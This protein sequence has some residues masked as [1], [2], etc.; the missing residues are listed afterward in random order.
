MFSQL[1]HSKKKNNNQSPTNDPSLSAANT[2]LLTLSQHLVL[3]PLFIPLH[4]QEFSYP[5]NTGGNFSSGQFCIICSFHQKW[6]SWASLVVQW[7]RINPLCKTRFD[8]WAR[9]IP[10]VVEQLNPCATYSTACSKAW[11]WQLLKPACLEPVFHNK[12]SHS[13]GKPTHH[14]ERVALPAA[15]TTESLCASMKTQRNQK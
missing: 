13:S 12:R 10:H 5:S 11:E 3:S 1:T 8:P 14:S 15:T 9:K 6:S 2:L 7:L 4:L